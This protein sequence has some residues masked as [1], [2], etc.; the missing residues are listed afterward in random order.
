MIL[1]GEKQAGV[2]QIHRIGRV[3]EG[4][5]GAHGGAAFTGQQPRAA[6]IAQIGGGQHAFQILLQKADAQNAPE[7]AAGHEFHI[8]HQYRQ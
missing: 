4:A 2:A 8:G 5:N 1:R 6:A 3:A 7:R